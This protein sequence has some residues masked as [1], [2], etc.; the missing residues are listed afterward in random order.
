MRP[1]SL[2]L[3]RVVIGLCCIFLLCMTILP[4]QAAR[5]SHGFAIT[6]FITGVGLKVGSTFVNTSA[7]EKYE[8]YLSATIQSD[9]QTL[10]DD[11]VV[12]RNAST[13]MS[14]VGYGFIGLAAVLSIF[15]QLH[16]ATVNTASTANIQ[17]NLNR[18]MHYPIYSASS[19]ISN[20]NH[21]WGQFKDYSLLPQYD[22]QRQR[23]SL[24]FLHRF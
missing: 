10:K 8:K 2:N 14:R 7:E 16:N 6:L 3:Q 9:I 11:V 24:Q 22:L 20:G 18:N 1:N 12:R 21:Y 17:N 23:I 4:A 15:N 5:R 13:S 19:P